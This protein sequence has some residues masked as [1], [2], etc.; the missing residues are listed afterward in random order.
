M[1]HIEYKFEFFTFSEKE[2]N[3]WDDFVLKNKIGSIHQISDWKNFQLKIPGREKVLGFGVKDFNS[4]KIL[5]TVFCVRMNTGFLNKY[6]WYSARGPVFD[7]ENT[8]AGRFLI[9]KVCE[10]LK[11]EGGLFWRID[12]YLKNGDESF[13]EKINIKSLKA[14]QNYQP[15]STLEKDL[16]KT[17]IELLSEMK[18][19]GRYNIK[20]AAKKGV[21][22]EIIENGEFTK[23]DLDDFYKLSNETTSRDKFSGHSK[24]YYENFLRMLKKQAV[25]FFATYEGVRIATAISTFY[26]DRSIYYFGASTSNSQYRKLMAPYLLQWEMMKYAKEKKCKT[27]DFLGIAPE[28]ATGGFLKNHAYAGITE[29][30]LKFGGYRKNYLSGREFVFSSIWYK[31][32]QLIKRRDVFKKIITFI[33][34]NKK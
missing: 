31:I 28:D 21:E 30:K 24:I 7:L 26:G 25:L 8:K 34:I 33:M 9:E 13:F 29:F 14:T 17:E 2:K 19:K 15:E 16:T 11:K 32:Y 3:N 12:P 18:R 1:K 10:V 5:A 4:Q 22:I 20:L 6:W 23:K 27:Y